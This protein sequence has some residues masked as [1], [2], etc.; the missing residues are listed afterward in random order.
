MA[1]VIFSSE[2]QRLTGEEKTEVAAHNYRDLLDRVTARYPRLDRAELLKMAVAID[3]VII[4]DPL[5]EHVDDNSE[6]HFLYKI[7]GG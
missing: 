2:L 5:L 1:H 3:G 7:S 4:H 6:V